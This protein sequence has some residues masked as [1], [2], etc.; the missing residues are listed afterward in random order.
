MDYVEILQHYIKDLPSDCSLI[1]EAI[2]SLEQHFDLI[3]KDEL[4]HHSRPIAIAYL[5]LKRINKTDILL[6]GEL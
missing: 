1:D 5:T 4:L 6:R 2:A 3:D